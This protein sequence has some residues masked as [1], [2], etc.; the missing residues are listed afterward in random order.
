MMLTNLADVLRAAG[1]EVEEVPG[2]KTRGHGQMGAIECI[3][4]HHT[5]GPARGEYP[6]LGTVRDG[7]PGLDGPLSQL[8]L[9][10]SG[11][12]LVIAAG[13]SW[14]AGVV[15]ESW[16]SN[17]H[18]IGIEAEA[19]G[20]DPWPAAQYASYVKG[21][22]ALREAYSVPLDHVVGHKEAAKPRG[23]KSDPNFDMDNFRAAVARTQPDGS[24]SVADVDRIL[25]YQ[26]ACAIQIQNNTRQHVANAT[27]Q[28]LDYVEACTSHITENTRQIDAGSDKQLTEQLATLK[29]DVAAQL[30]Q[31]AD[32]LPDVPAP[33]AVDG[34][35]E[36]QT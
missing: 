4:C 1:L 21:V 25:K 30:E 17:P 6:S 34:V 35:G 7:R 16:Q 15:F 22:R 20:T 3:M 24:L 31:L 18:A 10:R 29:A 5:A 9:A 26:E 12:W 14:H 2:W 23:R 32:Q 36:V 11:K 27:K 28:I 33:A 19:T 8:G 13:L